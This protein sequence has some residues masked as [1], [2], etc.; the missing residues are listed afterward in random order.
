MKIQLAD[1]TQFERVFDLLLQNANWL[2]TVCPKQ[3]PIQWLQEKKPMILQ[4]I[5]AKQVYVAIKNNQ[6]IATMQLLTLPE[7]V[8]GNDKHPA[9]YVHKLAID[10]RFKNQ[11]LG[12]FML[13]EVNIIAQ[14]KG[15]GCIRLD[16]VQANEFLKNYYESL[17]FKLMGQAVDEGEPI[18]LFEK[19]I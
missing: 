14:K 7:S 3:W 1:S 4:S 10:R 6:I 18:F 16:C 17:G 11:K 9:I 13:N 2:Q 19:S 8:W 15:I 12:A 5:E